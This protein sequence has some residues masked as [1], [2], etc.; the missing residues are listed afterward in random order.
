MSAE[1]LI[2]EIQEWFSTAKLMEIPPE[3]LVEEFISMI[4]V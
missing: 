1:E 4:I 2:L 3:I